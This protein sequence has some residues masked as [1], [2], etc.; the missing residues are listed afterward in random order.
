MEKDYTS[1]F[2]C[3]I[4]SANE[5]VN[6]IDFGLMPL[7]NNLN[8]SFQESLDCP[9][10]PLLVNYYP[11]SKLSMLSVSVNPYILFAHYVYKSGTSKPYID[12]CRDMYDYLAQFVTIEDNDRLVDIGGNDGTLLSTFLEKSNKKLDIINVDPSENLGKICRNKKIVTLTKMWDNT[13]GS[14][15]NS[16]CKV[17]TS[18]NVFQHVEDIVG[19]VDGIFHALKPDGIWCLEFPYWKKDLETYQYD[20]IYHEHI[21]YY[22]L[23][24]L[25]QLFKA[26]GLQIID[27]S[28]QKIHGGSLR[29]ISKKQYGDELPIPAPVIKILDAEKAFDSKFY[30]KWGENVKSH[31]VRSKTFLEDIKKSGKKIAGFGA[32]A[33]GCTFLNAAGIDYNIIDYIID[34]TDTKQNKFMPGTGIQIVSRKHLLENPTDYILVLAHNFADYIITSLNPIYK[35]KFILMFP[36]PKIY[37]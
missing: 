27:V 15:F 16:S 23:T 10:Y 14:W 35:G 26:R 3:P 21:Y 8:A 17:I 4:S 24:P 33:K 28:E 7:V 5:K 29:I 11:E 32:A 37:V 31:L 13:V 34:D 2:K 22:L 1:L 25:L 18:T 30:E 19:F 9:K 36:E 20:Q 6:Y 12:H